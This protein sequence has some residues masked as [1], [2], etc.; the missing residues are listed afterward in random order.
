[1]F[2]TTSFS[3]SVTAREGKMTMCERSLTAR[4][5][6]IQRMSLHDGP[7]IRTTVFFKGCNLHCFWCHNP[8]SIAGGAEVQFIPAR[9][10]GC[11]ECLRNCQ[12]GNHT[13]DAQGRHMFDRI[14]C[15]GCG[16]CCT[17]CPTGALRLVGEAWTVEA[18][19]AHLLRDRPFFERSGGGVTLSGGEPLLQYEFAVL[20]LLELKRLGIHTAIESALL[21]PYS[22]IERLLPVTD[23]FLV[24]MKHPDP[25]EHERAT[26]Q[27]NTEILSNI[28]L[29]DA[30]GARY[31]IRIPV[32]PGVNDNTTTF[33]AFNAFL[34]PLKNLGNVELMPYHAYG[35]S[36]YTSLDRD[37]SKLEALKAPDREQ[38]V[39][40]AECIHRPVEFRQG[41]KRIH[42]E[43]GEV[44]EE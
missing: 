12:W 10:I 2:R 22:T 31:W 15:I 9:C 13:I 44:W 23:L 35:L 21:V 24:D 43:G 40:L 37:S 16:R 25:V 29:L 18:L 11:G 1:M 8:E 32:V 34:E 3:V 38:L 7:G 26:G 36:K 17:A 19:V 5:S 6:N 42:V 30:S 33:Q 27:R 14:H 20:L 28:R 4:V 39:Q 41:S